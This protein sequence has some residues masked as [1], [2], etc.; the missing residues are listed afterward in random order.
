MRYS[1]VIDGLLISL[2]CETIKLV[3]KVR[4]GVLYHFPSPTLL[5]GKM[6][7]AAIAYYLYF[8]AIN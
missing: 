1:P 6:H 3:L 5:C 4:N 2:G 8:N 7:K